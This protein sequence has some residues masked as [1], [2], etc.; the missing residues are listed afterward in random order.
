[1][2]Q[3]R[4]AG[5]RGKLQAERPMM[6]T[7]SNYMRASLPLA[8]RSFDYSTRVQSYP[9]ALNDQL[10]DCTMA[11]VIHLLQLAYAEV[12]E[13]FQYPGDDVVRDTYMHLT[14]GQ[15]TGLVEHQVLQTWMN[16]GLFGTKIVAYAPL[17]IKNQKEL[18]AAC[19]A[20]GGIY[21]G[22]EMPTIAEQQFEAHQPWHLTEQ[23]PEPAGG[24][25]VVVTGSNRFGM[26]MITWGAEDS[27]TWSWWERYGSEAWVVIP[28]IFVEANHGP[29]WS[30][31]ISTL[32]ADIKTL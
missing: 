21:L 32:Q 27:M 22:V 14:N 15:D 28:E 1:M 11:G 5:K 6:G 17:D 20:F 29:V 18:S 13:T 30:I 9:M 12:G 19:Y 31:D 8:P 4:I 7:L 24:H 16:D 10:G 2:N 3:G 23:N 25:C 26:D